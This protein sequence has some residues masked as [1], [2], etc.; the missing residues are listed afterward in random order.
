MIKITI[1][2]NNIPERRYIIDIIFSDFLELE[3]LIIE[4]KD[5]QYWEI[6]LENGNKLIFEDCFFNKY[7]NDLE[8]LKF[9]NIPHKI[10]F[11]KNEFIVE[12][13]IPV[14]YGNNKLKISKNEII[15][16]ID[17]F[18]SIFFMLT[19]WEEYVNKARD[20]H[21]RFQ[22]KE[23][24]AYKSG[25]LDRPVVNEYIQMLKNIIL[26]LDNNIKFK[27][28]KPQMFVSCDVD[29]PFDCTVK[30][31]KQLIRTLIADIIKR[32]SLKEAFKRLRRYIFNKLENY[33]YDENYTFNWYMDIC[34]KVGL[35]AT[36]YF[37]PT[38]VEVHNGCYELKDQKIKKLIKYIDLKGH[39]IGVHGSYQTYQDKE[40]AKKQKAIL[41]NTLNSL[42]ISQKILGNRQHYLRW[43]SSVTPAILDNAGF[44]YD[45]TGGF[46]DIVGFRYGVCYEFRIF[47]FLNK[48]TLNIK[49]RPLIVMECTLIDD[50]YM[51]LGYS[52]KSVKVMKELK[53][54]C[55]K[56]GGNFSLLWHNN[57][58]KS[59]EAKNLFTKVLYA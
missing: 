55:Y 20:N 53:E 29:E 23:S 9:E 11:I 25:F 49:Q 3:F 14:I 47:D 35:K 39:K 58:F 32:K 43:D 1:P 34:D 42:G 6:E 13:D 56:Y 48:C 7:L 57:S 10:E 18:A 28:H 37:I 40:K 31:L 22:A 59:L 54:K 44:L 38:S 52:E 5:S 26:K 2:K 16:G 51:G 4:N 21:D 27:N 50:I 15:C 19:R 8:Y 46:A 33:K 41:E 36:F 30:N 12:N 24:L 45:T 17:I